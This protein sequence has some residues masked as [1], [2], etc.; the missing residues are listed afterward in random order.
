[1][2]M[3]DDVVNL[4]SGSF[5]RRRPIRRIE[6]AMSTSV[7][8]DGN[9]ETP[10]A[11]IFQANPDTFDLHAYLSRARRISWTARQLAERMQIGDRIYIWRAAGRAKGVSGI[12]ASGWLHDTPR[13]R[14]EDPAAIELWRQPPEPEPRVWID[15]DRAP[16]PRSSTRE[17]AQR[18][19]ARSP[20]AQPC[21]PVSSFR[22]R[23]PALTP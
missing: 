1:V 9:V 12:V 23:I 20:R 17:R 22:P 11:W 8:T 21:P 15:V 10:K 3:H 4:H 5:I 19:A 14:G 13:V 2:K 18:P 6:V 7:L 16:S